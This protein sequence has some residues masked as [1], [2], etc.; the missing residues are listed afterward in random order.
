M[1]CG[2]FIASFNVAATER[3]D[4][5]ILDPQPGTVAQAAR[6]RKPSSCD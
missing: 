2:V 5:R 6:V 4:P 1:N 3:H